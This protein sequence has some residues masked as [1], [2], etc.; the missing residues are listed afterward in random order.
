MTKVPEQNHII[1][2]REPHVELLEVSTK[3]VWQSRLPLSREE[4]DALSLPEDLI[5]IGNGIGVMEAHYFRR[6][7][8][9]DVD[10]PVTMRVID[11]IEFIHC[12][13]PPEDGAEIPIADGPQLLKVDKYHSLVFSFNAMV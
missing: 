8:G 4:A 2:C 11:S 6:S 9:S 10:G 12:A 5:Y 7:P 13:N 3:K 1:D